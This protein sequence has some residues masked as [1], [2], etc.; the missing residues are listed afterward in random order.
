MSVPINGVD[1]QFGTPSYPKS[2]IE[3]KYTRTGPSDILKKE[4]FAK[5]LISVNKNSIF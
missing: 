4:L 5:I 2:M 1:P 3:H